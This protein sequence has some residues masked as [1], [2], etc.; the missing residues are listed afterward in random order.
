MKA[1]DIYNIRTAVCHEAPVGL[2]QTSSNSEKIKPIVLA[3][4]CLCCSEGI[5][6]LAN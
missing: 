5:S 2:K 4:T 6:R 1:Q 3:I